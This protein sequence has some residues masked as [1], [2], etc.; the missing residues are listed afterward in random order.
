[1]GLINYYHIKHNYELIQ[2]HLF[3]SAQI[4]VLD[5]CTPQPLV[6]VSM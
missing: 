3:F 4:D 2:N 5:S 6:G 1:M